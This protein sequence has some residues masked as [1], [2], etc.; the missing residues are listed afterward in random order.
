MSKV[1]DLAA[2]ER[3]DLGDFQRC[4]RPRARRGALPSSG[5]RTAAQAS[6]GVP[7]TGQR[8]LGFAAGVG[9]GVDLLQGGDADLGVDLGGVEPGVSEQLLDEA[10]AGAVV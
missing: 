1:T 2:K 10:D 4:G 8:L 7:G 6:S 9:A 5:S 3:G